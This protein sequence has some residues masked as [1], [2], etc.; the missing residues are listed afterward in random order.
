MRLGLAFKA[1]IDDLRESPSVEIVQHLK[2]L[3]IGELFVV[4]P[5][6][7]ALPNNLVGDNV[8][9]ADANEAVAKADIVLLLV[10]HRAFKDIGIG[11]LASKVV[12]DTRGLWEAME[13]I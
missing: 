4:E 8:I 6:V 9:L 7:T 10:N 1:D 2:E 11:A 13:K 3:N 5:H 12:I